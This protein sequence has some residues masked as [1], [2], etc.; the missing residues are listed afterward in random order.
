MN[1]SP[2][3]HLGHTPVAR[4]CGYSTD[5]RYIKRKAVTFNIEATRNN[6]NDK[7]TMYSREASHNLLGTIAA[8]PAFIDKLQQWREEG[9]KADSVKNFSVELIREIEIVSEEEA[10]EQMEKQLSEGIINALF[11][12]FNLHEGSSGIWYPE[13]YQRY[14]QVL[15]KE[16]PASFFT[17][18]A[19]EEYFEKI[20]GYTY[21]IKKGKKAS[22][23]L[24]IFLKGPT[25]T[26]CVTSI[27]ACYYKA[28][29]DILGDEKFD[30][31]F[32]FDS[33]FRLKISQ[34]S[35]P[36][37]RD[38]RSFKKNERG[39]LGK[40]AL[41]IGEWC[42]FHGVPWYANK[43]PAGCAGAWNTVYIGDDTRGRQ[44]FMANSIKI[45]HSYAP[46]PTVHHTTLFTIK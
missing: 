19:N 26:D 5:G 14:L 17:G 7:L 24:K 23:A 13:D 16:M 10:L 34:T 9:D 4:L 42:H 2:I 32:D 45:V 35:L 38:M 28:V 3:T 41:R 20:G 36:F 29:L 31:L 27:K 37:L 40:R 8:C 12:F 43:H 39:L 25:I 22:A 15:G 18:Y 44:L 21:I 30:Q 33:P 1:P 11:E 46:P 6:E